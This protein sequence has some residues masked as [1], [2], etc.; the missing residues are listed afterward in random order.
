ME[1]ADTT[2][3]PNVKFRRGLPGGRKKFPRSWP[4]R[5]AA[6]RSPA[7]GRH[8]TLK[9]AL[10]F[11]ISLTRVRHFS[12]LRC[13]LPYRA[14]LFFAAFSVPYY[15]SLCSASAVRSRDLQ[16]RK[17]IRV[18]CFIDGNTLRNA[19]LFLLNVNFNDICILQLYDG[20]RI[21]KFRISFHEKKKRGKL[22][23]TCSRWILIEKWRLIIFKNLYLTGCNF[24]G[25]RP[26]A[27]DAK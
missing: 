11:Y 15:S 2:S 9:V 19:S 17:T 10:D 27:R 13:Q 8:R 7:A 4:P 23:E 20:E 25:I 1:P 22:N 6:P 5:R 14:A 18:S 21:S 24:T 16:R 12:S 3:R 26:W